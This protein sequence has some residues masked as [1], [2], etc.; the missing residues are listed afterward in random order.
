MKKLSSLKNNK[1]L[2]NLSILKKL[3]LLQKTA[4]IKQNNL[5]SYLTLTK[6]TKLK[7]LCMKLHIEFYLN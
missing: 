5:N 2:I 4:Q 6:D 3:G 1:K 7:H